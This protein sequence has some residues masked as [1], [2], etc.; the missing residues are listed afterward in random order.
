MFQNFHLAAAAGNRIHWNWERFQCFAYK[1]MKQ[2][3]LI[4]GYRCGVM[5]RI[6]CRLDALGVE[7]SMRPVIE[8][9]LMHEKGA[10]E[11]ELQVF[12]GG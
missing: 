1:G 3:G 7:Y 10:C 4:D 11:E 2:A 12:Q 6:A 8:G 9:C 5:Y